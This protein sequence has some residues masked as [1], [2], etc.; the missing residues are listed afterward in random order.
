MVAKKMMA[1]KLGTMSQR[2]QPF[3]RPSVSIGWAGLIEARSLQLN[4]FKKA[5][6]AGA[7]KDID[8]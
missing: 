5:F 8:G 2:R 1:W 3:L 6:P 4:C 7:Q